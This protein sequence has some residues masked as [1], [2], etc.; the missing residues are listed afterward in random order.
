M[1]DFSCRRREPEKTNLYG[2]VRDHLAEFLQTAL[3][4]EDDASIRGLVRENLSADG[5][6]VLEAGSP[7][8]ALGIIAGHG[9]SIRLIL[10]DQIM[11]EMSGI[12]MVE[13]MIRAYPKV[14][15][16][17]MSGYVEDAHAWDHISGAG[18][19]FISKPFALDD[20]LD[21]VRRSLAA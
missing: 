11:P 14:R 5:F 3:L 9:D 6:H 2:I 4:V 7:G 1:S 17:I 20:L 12:R 19:G 16:I 10:T 21:R 15:V 8:E 13:Q 18:D